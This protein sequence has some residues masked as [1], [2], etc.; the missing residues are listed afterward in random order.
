MKRKLFHSVPIGLVGIFS[1]LNVAAQNGI[2]KGKVQRSE[3]ILPGATVSMET[4]VVLTDEKGEFSFP[5]KA[6]NYT[7]IITHAG[8][9]KIVRQVNI[10]V[11]KTQTIE[12]IMTPNDLLGEIV[13]LGSRSLVHRSNLNTPV[14]VDA[15]SPAQL[16]QSGQTSLM[17]MLNFT[18]PS[19]NA[20]L[21]IANEPVTLRGLNPD[22]TL[23][24]LNG[25]RYNNIA[26]INPGIVP[27]GELGKGSV[28]NDLNSIPFPA[29]ERIEIL[30]DGASAQYG[31]D[32]IAGVINIVLKETT[33]KT[34]VNLH[35]GQQYKGDGENI[36][37]GIYHGISLNKKG[38]LA[39]QRGFLNFSADFHDRYP[40]YRRG[41]YKG[42]V[43]YEPFFYP[44][45]QRDSIIAEDNKKIKERGF[46]RLKASNGG[47]TQ[48]TSFGIL[49]NGAYRIKNETEL[50]WTGELNYR[51]GILEGPHLVP[52]IFPVVNTELFPDGFKAR[53]EPNIWNIAAIAGVKGIAG[54]QIHWQYSSSYGSNA[55][56]FYSKNTN[57]PSQQFTLGKSAPTTFYTGSLIY[58]QLTNT[59][60]F[61]KNISCPAHQLKT[62]NLHWGGELRFENFKTKK[63]E[64][65]AWEDYDPSGQKL[66]SAQIALVISKDDQVDKNRS[67]ACTYI[68]V[69]TEL[70]DRLLINIAGRYE[71][72]SDFGGNL[73]GKLAARYKLSDK[74]SLRGSVS[75]GFRAPSIQQRY[76]SIIS[77]GVSRATLSPTITGLFNNEHPVTKAF[78]IP[79]L[80]AER[81]VNFSGGFTSTPLRNIYLTV[82]AYQIHIK[83]RVVLSGVF[84]RRTNAE[85][86]NLLNDNSLRDYPYID[87]VSF[88][89]N[90][91]NTRTRGIDIVING[92]WSVHKEA[93][94]GAMLAVNFTKTKLVGAIKTT[95]KLHADSLLF[96]IEEKAKVEKGQ[97]DSKIVLNLN[98]K[99]GKFV[100]N[101][102]NTRF[103]KTATTTII[104]NPFNPTD[105]DTLYEFF[106]AKIFT[107]ISI[108]YSPKKWMAITAGINNVFDVHPDPLK[109]YGNTFEGRLIY[110]NDASP[111]GFNGGYYFVSM[112]FNW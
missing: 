25:T 12:F 70:K 67:I 84:D 30:R 109:N 7:V 56:R 11:G 64:E 55:Y 62:I 46:D 98:Y 75:T 33:N 47:T 100:F 50:F 5:L 34:S 73:A 104:T 19:L 21:P 16:S 72:Y 89:T 29:I 20:S 37:L 78:G 91:I 4:K 40:T 3:G 1:V 57:N 83:N 43:Y 86:D 27:I 24:L 10:E 79:S 42:T 23:I 54:K 77:K 26:Y 60:H 17:Q 106:S 6:G 22:Q 74:L 111:F 97:P 8:Y 103:G 108:A 51:T 63:G 36:N 112:R 88:F 107:D 80:Q 96:N 28:G 9:K 35:L 65:A 49:I 38:R 92:N 48:H 2:I 93:S 71:H 14:P 87:Q 94:L 90:A 110:S 13:I 32:A 31:S 95:D 58:H 41:E 81:S 105:R 99:T 59:I 101:I 53:V 61:T 68:D 15:F 52:K 85:V 44:P 82:D 39:G 102:R 76:Y 69:E 66:G 45:S 18:A